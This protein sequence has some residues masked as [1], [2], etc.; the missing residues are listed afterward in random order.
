MDPVVLVHF[1]H[2]LSAYGH[3]NIIETMGKCWCMNGGWISLPVAIAVQPSERTAELALKQWTAVHDQPWI[4][5]PWYENSLAAAM[6][7]VGCGCPYEDWLATADESVLC[8]L[9]HSYL[10]LLW[11]FP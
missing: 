3:P 1:S 9:L 8:D 4:E 2:A 6:I 5:V 10:G 7:L 11:V